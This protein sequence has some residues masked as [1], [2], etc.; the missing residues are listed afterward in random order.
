ME[1]IKL[2]SH[3]GP[4]GVLKLE[5]PVGL[6]NVEY[7]VMVIMQPVHT[8]TPSS[9]ETAKLSPEEP[10]WPPGF[11]EQTEGSLEDD[12]IKRPSQGPYETSF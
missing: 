6:S 10:G 9:P 11:F 12:P 1:S 4:D 5:V 2:Q 3:V 8:A 7:E